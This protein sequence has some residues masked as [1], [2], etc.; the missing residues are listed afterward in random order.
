MLNKFPEVPELIM[1]YAVGKLCH[2][3][4]NLCCWKVWRRLFILNSS[5]YVWT[6]RDSS[7]VLSSSQGQGSAGRLRTSSNCELFLCHV[8]PPHE[9]HQLQLT[10]FSIHVQISGY[11]L[12]TKV[13]LEPSLIYFK[14]QFRVDYWSKYGRQNNKAFSSKLAGEYLRGLGVGKEELTSISVKNE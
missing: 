7:W 2:I 4:L 5:F 13:N 11:P 3:C 10:A 9:S 1:P 6:N 12:G 14:N 8:L